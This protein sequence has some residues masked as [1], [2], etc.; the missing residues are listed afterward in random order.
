[1]TGLADRLGRVTLEPVPGHPGQSRE[2]AESRGL[3]IWCP[4]P[5]AEGDRLGCVRQGTPPT[6]TAPPNSDVSAVTPTP[7]TTYSGGAA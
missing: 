6:V 5:L 3:C 4:E 1:M 2:P 7:P